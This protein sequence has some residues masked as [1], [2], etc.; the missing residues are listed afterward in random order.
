M[1]SFVKAMKGKPITD[2]ILGKMEKKLTGIIKITDDLL[3]LVD[4]LKK[5][6]L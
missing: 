5:K 6:L 2:K 1:R 3:V 4:D